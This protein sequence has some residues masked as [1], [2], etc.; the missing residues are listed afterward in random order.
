MIIRE[1]V[2]RYKSKKVIKDSDG[3][4]DSPSKVFKFLKPIIG[5]ATKENF[6]VILLNNKNM[7]ISWETVSVGTISETILHPREI[8]VAA[9][10]ELASSI[11]VAHNH[12]SGVLHPS[13]EDIAATNR[14]KEVGAIVG[15]ELLDH[16]I[17]GTDSYLSLK[18][19][20]YMG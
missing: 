13:K 19:A 5:D 1:V 2:L 4:V 17:V 9:I 11:I 3:V 6:V 8:F 7:M 12:P 14:L 10:R 18:E 15:I 20:G 16:V